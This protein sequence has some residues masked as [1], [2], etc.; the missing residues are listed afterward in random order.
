VL[1]IQC[2]LMKNLFI[3]PFIR[4]KLQTRHGVEVREVEQCFE[5]RCGDYLE[6][7]RAQH[8]TDPATNWFIAPTNQG[9]LLKIVF[10]S[11]EGTVFLKSAFEPNQKEIAIY[12]EFAK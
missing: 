1:Y 6:D 2:T 3:S 12:E 4:E 9:R 7:T 10:V 8:K 5:N 11:K